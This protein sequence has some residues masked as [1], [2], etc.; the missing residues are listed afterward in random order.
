V[1]IALGTVAALSSVFYLNSVQSR[2]NGN[3]KLIRVYKITQVIP[4]GATG[5]EAIAH[6]AIAASSIPKKFYPETA[7]TDLAQ[8]KGLVAPVELD[9]G[10]VLVNDQFVEPA[11]ANT[12]FSTTNVPAG[13]VAITL[14]F[15]TTQAVAGLI[16]PGDKV[17]MIGTFTNPTANPN[18]AT[19]KSEYS[20]FFYQNVNVIAIGTTAA[21][22]AGN[23][24]A[25]TNPGS[26]LYTFAVP[27]EAAERLILAD[28]EDSITL[29][30]VP[31][32]NTP[33]PIPPVQDSNIDNPGALTPY[34]S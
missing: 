6:N 32:D 14:S 21:P 26:G 22:T 28:A 30:L 7:I 12:S 2:A 9:P 27:P 34:G 33:V 1:A 31:P 3:A 11:V 10:Q 20:H 19:G 18:S 29:A 24:T 15:G 16:V 23:S 25:P 8:I 4:K 5:D 13:E 17:D